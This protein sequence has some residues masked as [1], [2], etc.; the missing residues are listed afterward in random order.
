M[1]TKYRE[2]DSRNSG[3]D[4]ALSLKICPQDRKSRVIQ[5][6]S[7]LLSLT[8][9]LIPERIAV[10]L[11]QAVF[12]AEILNFLPLLPEWHDAILK[13]HSVDELIRRLAP[14]LFS[15]IDQNVFFFSD[16]RRV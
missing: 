13:D 1:K 6:G 14:E 12:P 8:R 2:W 5:I 3:F 7:F 4:L 15:F 9:N 11:T 10:R 16:E